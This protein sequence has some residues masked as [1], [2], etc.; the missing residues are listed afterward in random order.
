MEENKEG[1][2][3]CGGKKGGGGEMWRRK[4]RGGVRCGGE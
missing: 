3:R 1:G 4:R 2:V